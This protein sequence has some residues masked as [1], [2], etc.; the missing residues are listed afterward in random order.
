MLTK[1]RRQMISLIVI[2]TKIKWH[3]LLNIDIES[4]RFVETSLVC[5]N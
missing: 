3:P 2:I 4:Q 1:Y 5:N